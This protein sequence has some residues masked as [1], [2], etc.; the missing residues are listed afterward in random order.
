MISSTQ[1]LPV[2]LQAAIASIV[3]T[4]MLW[5][6][7]GAFYPEK[8][9]MWAGADPKRKLEEVTKKGF[10]TSLIY[11]LWMTNTGLKTADHWGKQITDLI[12]I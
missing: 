12:K 11:L 7:K 4:A 1:F 3:L 9:A 5:E 10:D 2:A 8:L 6:E